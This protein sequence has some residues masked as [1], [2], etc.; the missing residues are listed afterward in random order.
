[1]QRKPFYCQH[2]ARQEAYPSRP[3]NLVEKLILALLLL[4]AVRCGRC[5]RRYYRSV[6]VQVGERV[7]PTGTRRAAA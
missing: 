5:D 4:R 6:S 2:C 3:R 7:A 1:M